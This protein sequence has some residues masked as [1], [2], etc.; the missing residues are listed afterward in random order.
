MINEIKQK[1]SNNIDVVINVVIGPEGGFSN[2][3][4]E[5]AESKGF[6]ILSLG[7]RILRTETAAVTALSIL[8]Y[9]MS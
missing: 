6:R 1:M 4:I 2:K 7:D 9:E 8:M 3:E 5:L